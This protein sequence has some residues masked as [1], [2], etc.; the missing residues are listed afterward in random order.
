[1]HRFFGFDLRS[2]HARLENQLPQRFRLRDEIPRRESM[3]EFGTF[4]TNRGPECRVAGLERIR[5]P[6][7]DRH[8]ATGPHEAP[9]ASSA[10]HQIREKEDAEDTYDRIELLAGRIERQQVLREDFNLSE[11]SRVRLAPQT[12]EQRVGD[13]HRNDAAL[14][15]DGFSGRNRRRS[16]AG[17]NIE[18]VHSWPEIEARDRAATEALPERVGGCVVRIG[19]GIVG[20]CDPRAELG[21]R[22]HRAGFAFR[23]FGGLVDGSRAQP[24]F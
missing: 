12:R 2:G 5:T 15:T 22:T 18:D 19:C 6:S 16:G 4:A 21:V 14:R 23:F 1:M 8:L 13:V 11:P 9:E 17:T 24:S 7:S 10:R 3:V 20:G